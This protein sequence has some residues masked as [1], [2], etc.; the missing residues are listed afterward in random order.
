MN[1]EQNPD[2]LTLK[3][4]LRSYGDTWK[5]SKTLESIQLYVRQTSMQRFEEYDNIVQFH[6]KDLDMNIYVILL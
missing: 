5:D 2:L 1:L 6:P 3:Q 4:F